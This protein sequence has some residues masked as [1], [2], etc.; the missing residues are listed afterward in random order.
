MCSDGRAGVQNPHLAITKVATEASYDAVGEVIHY[1][2]VATNDGNV[3]LHNVTVT[4][5]NVTR[6]E[7]SRRRPG[8]R[9]G[10]GRVDHLHGDAHGDAGRPRRGPLLEH[11]L[12]RRRSGRGRR[13][14]VTARTCRLQ[15]PHLSIEKTSTTTVD[16]DGRAGR[17]LHDRGDEH[18]QRRRCTGDHRSSDDKHGDVYAGHRLRRWRRARSMTCTGNHTVTQADLDAG[19]NLTNLA[20]TADSVGGSVTDTLTIPVS[21]RLEGPHHAHRRDVQRL[22]LEQPERR[23]RRA[24]TTASRAARSTR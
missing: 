22:R 5:P 19:G 4:D 17:A 1:T 11:G 20:T 3:T 16:H 2:I 14:C 12:C 10:A 21:R 9:S 13:R 18:G 23:T 15:N 24:A 7:L 8:R 6:A